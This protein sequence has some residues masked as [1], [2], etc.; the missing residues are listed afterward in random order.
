MFKIETESSLLDLHFARFLHR[1]SGLTGVEG[2]AFNALVQRLSA[3][4]GE[5]HSCIDCAGEEGILQNIPARLCISEQEY[6]NGACAPLVCSRRKLFLYR[7]YHYEFRLARQIKTLAGKQHPVCA[8]IFPLLDTLFPEEQEEGDQKNLQKEAVL[9]ALV[10][11]FAIISGGPGT[12]KT[13]TVVKILALLIAQAQY[14]GLGQ[15]RVAL[16]APTGRAAMRLGES[17]IGGVRNL[18]V[19]EEIKKR[20]PCAAMTLHRLLGVRRNSNSFI[21]DSDNPLHHS[22]VVVDEASMVDLALMSKLVDALSP[23]CRLLLLG[24]K[25]Q[26]VSVESGSVLGELLAGLPRCGIILEKS[27]RFDTNIKALAMAVK[28]GKSTEAWELLLAS[29]RQNIS[30]FPTNWLPWLVERLILYMEAVQ[31]LID[32]RRNS[33]RDIAA[34]FVR[35]RSFQILCAMR[36][37]QRGIE[38]VNRE[39][40]QLLAAQGFVCKGKNGEETW[41]PG[42]P[43][44]ITSN[45]YNLELF[46]GDIGICLPNGRGETRVWFER[47]DGG[48][49]GFPAGR[50]PDHETAFAITIHKSQGSEFEEVA[51]LLP[52]KEYRGLSRELLYTAITRAKKN[53]W[54]LANREVFTAAVS[55]PVTRLSGLRQMLDSY[56]RA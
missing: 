23:G 14:Q 18:P 5:G 48:I 55:Q 12:G 28:N 56:I 20:I 4:L 53:V 13:T 30:L 22:V 7:Y 31:Q 51:V 9:L 26:L 3:A 43:V 36:K 34:L 15:F 47:R 29:K 24:D 35:L 32:K 46:N 41:Y 2:E 6:L 27:Y 52:E 49:V 25:D 37:G 54:L 16:T 21:H 17:I 8:D 19:A 1:L 11:N 33:E 42:R 10:N 45:D 44:I 40:V 38:Q 39:I 50:L